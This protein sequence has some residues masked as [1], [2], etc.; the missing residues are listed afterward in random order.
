MPER[1]EPET[2]EEKLERLEIENETLKD[3]D[4]ENER[5]KGSE[6]LELRNKLQSFKQ[7]AKPNKPLIK[8]S[9]IFDEN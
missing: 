9:S 6:K 1:L 7:K 3:K 8:R 4:F 2:K 5:R